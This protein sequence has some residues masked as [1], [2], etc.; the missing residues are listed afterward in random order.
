[1]KFSSNQILV[2]KALSPFWAIKYH[3]RVTANRCFRSRL[4]ISLRMTSYMAI[5]VSPSIRKTIGQTRQL[6]R[7]VIGRMERKIMVCRPVGVPYTCD[8][9]DEW[10]MQCR[11]HRQ[12]LITAAYV[13]HAVSSNENA[14]KKKRLENV[15]MKDFLEP[16]SSHFLRRNGASD[17]RLWSKT[18]G[19]YNTRIRV[20]IRFFF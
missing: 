5:F 2:R 20:I 11:R 1:M 15:C 12:Q 17:R 14:K 9:V 18:F 16:P 4:G 3:R 8:W 6:R 10:K 7:S 19:T 13:Y